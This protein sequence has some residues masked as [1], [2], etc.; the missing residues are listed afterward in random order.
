MP[1]PFLRILV[2]HASKVHVNDGFAMTR[3]AAGAGPV[4]RKAGA[5]VAVV[6]RIPELRERIADWRRS[7]ARVAL[8]PT[9]G[10]LHA[11]HRALVRLAREAAERVVVSIFVNPRQFGPNED[12]A[13]YPRT[14]EADLEALREEGA[15]A[16]FVPAVA[17]MY[18]PGF[19]TEV[20]RAG[21]RA[22]SSR[23]RTGRGISTG[24]ATVVTKLLIQSLPDA[25]V[26]GEKDWQQLVLVRRLVADLD[27]PV[28]HPAR[29]PIVREPDGLAL[30]SR[31]LYLSP[32]ARR[33]APRLYETLRHLKAAAE[34][35]EA[36][37]RALE[38]E[39]RRRLLAG[40]LRG[41]GLS[42][43]PRCRHPRTRRRSR[44][45]GA[46]ACDRAA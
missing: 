11:G 10:A 3:A 9:M 8:V 41:R 12:Y 20:D 38:D 2:T 15:D 34:A 26:F 4:V 24:V 43:L 33:I 13:R 7:G 28:Q 17:E 36:P 29:V 31:N 39:G 44:A 25:A 21:A 23:G 32:A 16:A 37:L 6:E 35:G 46:P 1:A 18:A 27:L 40:R 5:M 14:L 22:R 30:S 19:A 45:A 42:D